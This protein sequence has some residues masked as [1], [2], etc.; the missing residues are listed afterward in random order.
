MSAQGVGVQTGAIDVR[1]GS[2]T[3]KLSLQGIAKSLLNPAE[4]SQDLEES[5]QFGVRRAKGRVPYLTGELH[6]SI[7]YE[8]SGL[9]GR[10]VARA[11]H[12]VP[13]E[14]GHRTRSGSFVP[15]Q[16]YLRPSADELFSDLV[17]RINRRIE[18]KGL[19][20]SSAV[21]R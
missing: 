9:R 1:S 14:M 11:D 20:G 19:R 16:P 5:L 12:A 4:L 10:L 7:D 18:K 3:I 17:K 15:A 2:I 13:V 6:G 8:L 21:R